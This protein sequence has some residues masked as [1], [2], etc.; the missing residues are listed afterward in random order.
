MQPH[1]V[2]L[3][4][5]IKNSK[6]RRFAVPVYYAKRLHGVFNHVPRLKTGRGQDDRSLRG[7]P[8]PRCSYDEERE[9][10]EQPKKQNI[11]NNMGRI[12]IKENA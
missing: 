10:G 9:R 12:S 6:A 2:N 4:R 8:R 1:L 3:E 11:Y 5:L 7:L